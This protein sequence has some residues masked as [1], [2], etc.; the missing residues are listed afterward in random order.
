MLINHTL[1]YLPAQ[2]L[3]PLALLVSMVLWTHWLTP[4]QMGV[5][6]LVTVTQELAYLACLSWFSVYVLRYLPPSTDAD[7]RLRYLGTENFAL[8]V[9][10]A[11]CMVASVV[12]ALMLAERSEWI[13]ASMAVSAYVCTRS[14]S[15][16]YAERAR[17]QSA[18]LAYTSLQVSG[19][20]LGLA[21]GWLALQ[22]V[23][24]DAWTLLLAYAAAQALGI[25][26]AWPLMGMHWRGMRVDAQ[27]LKAAAA[28]GAPML[29][30]GLLGWVGENYI[31]YLVQWREGAAALGL[32]VVGWAL[33][34]RCASVASMLVATAAF[35]LAA[36][37]LNEGKR[38]EAMA[39]LRM[40]AALMLAVLVPVT[41]GV[42]LLGAT[43]VKLTVAEEYRELTTQMLAISMFAAAL[44]NLHMH[45]TD[46]L[47]VLDRQ[48]M[49]CAKVDV[50][51]IVLCA[52]ASLIA[53]HF[54]GLHGAV[55]GQALGS[56]VALFLSVY[57]ART[58]LGFVWPT[59]ETL[60]IVAATAVMALALYALHAPYTLE[61]LI[62]A[63]LVGAAVYAL[64]L[65]ALFWTDLRRLVPL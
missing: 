44:R 21:F 46:Q 19:P 51:E 7:A 61:G 32:M 36:R 57:W 11:A 2:L 33:G 37:L 48:L 22:Y 16:H 64:A 20:V 29:A 60:K 3:S 40:N 30:L 47:M 43:L 49:M 35:P 50:V 24:A 10:T 6:T 28:F 42:E 31:R 59:Q 12:T 4:E 39:Q 52:A 45:I 62:L 17:A 8:L 18:F 23:Q 1:R 34:R 56:A 5:F 65:A 14:A 25:V 26:L 58:K 63:V 54:N 13:E 55:M 38:A 27:L 15:T 9:G 53:L 41:V